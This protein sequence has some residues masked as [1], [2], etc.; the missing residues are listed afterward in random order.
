M[1]NL[2]E[3]GNAYTDPSV[4]KQYKDRNAYTD[5]SIVKLYKDGNHSG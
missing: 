2:P 4:V 5:P 1:P 3:S